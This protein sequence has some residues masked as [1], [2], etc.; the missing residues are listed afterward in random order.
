ML[1]TNQYNPLLLPTPCRHYPHR[2]PPLPLPILKEW[3]ISFLSRRLFPSPSPSI[4][5]SQLQIITTIFQRK[6][7][8]QL[9]AEDL[10]RILLMY[11]PPLFLFQFHPMGCGAAEA[12]GLGFVCFVVINPCV[13]SANRVD[14]G[15]FLF[16]KFPILL[17]PPPLFYF[18]EAICSRIS[19]PN[20]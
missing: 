3:I 10:K 13:L 12:T 20:Q 5:L 2:D 9:T 16:H 1:Y 15:F 7:R 4:P 11:V 19:K 8:G 17:P 14:L 18:F 6:E